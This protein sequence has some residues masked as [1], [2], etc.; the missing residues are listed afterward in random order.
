MA[1]MQFETLRR[2]A[3]AH[4]ST[5][6]LRAE[7]I[8]AAAAGFDRS[9]DCSQANSWERT[10]VRSNLAATHCI[11]ALSTG[12]AVNRLLT[13]SVRKFSQ[14]TTATMGV[15]FAGGAGPAFGAAPPLRLQGP[16]AK[17]ISIQASF[18]G[19]RASARP[20]PRARVYLNRSLVLRRSSRCARIDVLS[21]A[22]MPFLHP[23]LASAKIL[24]SLVPSSPPYPEIIVPTKTEE[25]GAI[26][27][28]DMTLRAEKRPCGI[29]WCHISRERPCRAAPAAAQSPP[30]SAARIGVGA[31]LLGGSARGVKGRQEVFARA[32]SVKRGSDPSPGRQTKA[33]ARRVTR[34]DE[35]EDPFRAPPCQSARLRDV[36]SQARVLER[37]RRHDCHVLLGGGAGADGGFATTC[38]GTRASFHDPWA[39]STM[40]PWR[41]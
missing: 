3:R 1:A 14:V 26:A 9:S 4:R 12:R 33:G 37:R 20:T 39:N 2:S 24:D 15:L 25:N 16:G 5:A 27:V 28:A 10:S 6:R 17:P 23:R 40:A 13:V 34:V 36:P 38:P 18:C 29:T 8:P 21:R 7:R 31:T 35:H 32:A 11:R 41:V 22:G 19:S 30:R